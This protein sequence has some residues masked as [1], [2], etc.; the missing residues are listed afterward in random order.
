MKPTNV[1]KLDWDLI[2]DPDDRQFWE[3]QV[4]EGFYK[5]RPRFGKDGSYVFVVR[6]QCDGPSEEDRVLGMV[7]K[8]W[9]AKK[10]AQ[11]DAIKNRRLP[12]SF[13]K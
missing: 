3:A 11:Q 7:G 5:I 8:L 9:E 12:A 13:L 10:I 4:W 1:V 2:E 6:F